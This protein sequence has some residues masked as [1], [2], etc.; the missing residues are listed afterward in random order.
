MSRMAALAAVFAAMVGIG[1][2]IALGQAGR[3][4][5]IGATTATASAPAEVPN[6]WIS[7]GP[8]GGGHLRWPSIS[9]Y[10]K[11]LYFVAC[12]MGGFYRSTDAG[13]SW[14]MIPGVHSATSPAIF[15]PTDANVV[16]VFTTYGREFNQGWK[17]FGSDDRGATWKT[18]HEYLGTY[19][20]NYGM[21]LTFMPGRPE[22]M[23]AG[24]SGN[25][26]GKILVSKDGGNFW[27]AADGTGDA[28]KPEGLAALGAGQPL[29]K[30]ADV[31]TIVADEF[32]AQ[33]VAYA[34]TSVGVYTGGFTTGG[35]TKM[36]TQPGDGRVCRLSSSAK[37]GN[38]TFYAISN[39][40]SPGDSQWW[41]GGHSLYKSADRG[42]TWQDLTANIK[43]GKGKPRFRAVAVSNADANIVYASVSDTD[44]AGEYKS[45]D[46]GKTWEFM[47]P[48]DKYFENING[49]LRGEGSH[50]QAG[51][52]TKVFNYGWGGEASYMAVCPTDPNI[53]NR[54]DDGRI[55][56]TRDG[57][58][59]WQQ[60]YTD[61]AKGDAW[62][63]RGVEVTNCYDVYFDPANH[64]RMYIAYTD[65][66]MFRSDD[67]GKSWTWSLK[68]AKHTNT[69]YEMVIDPAN[70]KRLWAA[71]SAQHDM[72]EW[73][74]LTPDK[75]KYQ[76][77]VAR[78]D[79]GGLNWT[80]VGYGKGLPEG[81][82]SSLAM[83]PAS[84]AEGRTL[85]AC[86]FGY[87][88]YKSTDGGD[89][90]KL[91][92][93]GMDVLKDNANAW[94]LTVAADG[95]LYA[96][97][98]KNVERVN[99]K[100]RYCGSAVYRSDDKAETWTRIGPSTPPA[101]SNELQEFAYIWDIAASKNDPGTVYVA[102]QEDRHVCPRS[103]GGIY[104]SRDKGKTWEMI[105][106]NTAV[107]RVSP[108]MWPSR[109]RLGSPTGTASAATGDGA[110]VPPAPDVLYAST[111]FD[112][113]YGS[114]DGGTTWNP[115][116]GLPFPRCHK[117]ELDP[118]NPAVIWITTVGASVFKGPATGLKE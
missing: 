84:P 38:I 87:G 60:L 92:D 96:C 113:V 54:T 2:A 73:K 50:F 36:P 51:W 85:Y 45:T 89:N 103:P 42:K 11:N 21:C 69:V 49:P 55:I 76:G 101:F 68:G 31:L 23:L 58:A 82:C 116:K 26:P 47:L 43:P 10:D 83:D 32:N 94:R 99:N 111:S 17:L 74:T 78:S 62:S 4:A 77:G 98:T 63:S 20:T 106:E 61:Q 40:A 95:T 56:G 112:G 39:A 22:T 14:Q 64:D 80:M 117:V 53:V 24:M 7:V 13:K 41:T 27:Q 16:Y 35:W 105:F 44:R 70:P 97:I 67:H 19:D 108:Q 8:G 91:M 118:D 33:D 52:Q 81:S 102:T 15:H 114:F 5:G 12:D 66:G 110:R 115:L 88:V 6:K 48:G 65:M 71:M 79:D 93:K 46:G 90:W 104:R 34:A 59:T 109:P 107:N 100:N 28:R 86:V 9:P 37:E 25:Q 72:P 1:L 57:G 29:P 18:L 30:E 75:K 3:P